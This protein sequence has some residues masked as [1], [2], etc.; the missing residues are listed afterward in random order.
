MHEKSGNRAGA[1]KTGRDFSSA[2]RYCN[3][4]NMYC[5]NLIYNAITSIGT[6]ITLIGTAITLTN[7]L[8]KLRF[9]TD[10]YGMVRILMSALMKLAGTLLTS[11]ILKKR[12]SANRLYHSVGR[13]CAR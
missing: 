4:F 12:K 6:A 5:N 2:Q 11:K 1:I 3:N 8:L 7:I 10:F 9:P 13:N